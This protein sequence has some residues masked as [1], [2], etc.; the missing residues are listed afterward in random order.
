MILARIGIFIEDTR[1]TVTAFRRARRLEHFV[2]E[3]AEDPVATLAAELRS[4]GLGGGRVHLGLDRGR[5][6]V[7]AIELPRTDQ[8][9][10]ARML[11]FDLEHHLPFP[12]EEA[13]FDWV[14]LRSPPPAPRRVL[15]AATEGRS[16]E[17]ARALVSGV[18]R[19]ASLRVAGHALTGLLP[20]GLP[21]RHT[22]WVHRHDGAADLLLLDGRTLLASRQVP[23]GDSSDLAREIKRSVPLARWSA[24][25]EVWLS[26]DEAPGSELEL[27]RSLAVRVSPPPFAPAFAPL[28][29]ALP[30]H[31]NGAALLALA[32]AATPRRPALN[33]LPVT[34]RPF[35]P[36]R[37]QLVTAGA[38][39]VAALLGLGLVLAHVIRTERYVGRVTEETRRLE[40]EA[41]AVDALVA[42]LARTRR[43]LT[44]LELAQASR[45]PALPALR[46]LT[47]TLP[48]GVWLQSLTMDRQ[49]VEL[50]GQADA[51]STLIPLLEASPRLERVEFTSPVTKTQNKE[52]FRLRAAWEALPDS[53]GTR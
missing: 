51:A 48:A 37:A 47:E 30:V 19:P 46:E 28:V 35:T 13:R 2:V 29:A 6:V 39:L 25:D 23:A 52:Q 5:A 33:L 53:T 9:D 22:V 24:I 49:G 41:R 36:S 32:L 18:A 8:G 7:K 1:L 43:V 27:G 4:R 14:E 50:T 16:V 44:A 40:L 10:V 26:G 17:R 3:E 20:H 38:M 21:A 42:D 45:V 12:P 34:A 31:R 11:E 15:L